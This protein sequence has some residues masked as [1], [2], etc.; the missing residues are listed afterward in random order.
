[1]PIDDESNGPRPLRRRQR[2]SDDEGPLDTHALAAGFGAAIDEAS[3]AGISLDELLISNP[4]STFMM[5]CQGDALRRAGL[6]SGDV[7]IVDRSI[8]SQ[9][10]QVVIAVVDG[11]LVVRLLA[12]EGGALALASDAGIE[13]RGDEGF[14]IWGVVTA[15]I[16]K[17][18]T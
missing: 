10:G 11:E 3:T 8:T 18:P 17:M 4:V 5:R 6:A 12:R 16:R 13:H 14:E 15:S 2:N 9:A 7:L 1:M